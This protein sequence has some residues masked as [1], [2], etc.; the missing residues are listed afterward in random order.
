M[1][2]KQRGDIIGD[3]LGVAVGITILGALIYGLAHWLFDFSIAGAVGVVAPFILAT[4]GFATLWWVLVLYFVIVSVFY[5]EDWLFLGLLFLGIP[6]GFWLIANGLPHV[7]LL[8]VGLYA[9][10]W[11]TTG[12]IWSFIK[13]MLKI[14]NL[15]TAIEETI[16][17]WPK[18]HEATRYGSLNVPKEWVVL[19]AH[20]KGDFLYNHLPS[21]L[22]SMLVKEDVLKLNLAPKLTKNKARVTQWI[23]YWPFSVLNYVFGRLLKD[24]INAII[25]KLSGVYDAVSRWMMRGLQV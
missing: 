16:T 4:A 25:T 20:E 12:V 21:R 11:L 1:R 15:R 2:S 7:T 13:W 8:G 3:F 14:G 5:D 23:A 24:I 6:A 19:E 10:Y 9:C 17:T 18:S 22:S